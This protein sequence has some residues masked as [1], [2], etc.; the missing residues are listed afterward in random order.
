MNHEI[1]VILVALLILVIAVPS[2]LIGLSR[3]ET[4]IFSRSLYITD[5]VESDEGYVAYVQW[6]FRD[7]GNIYVRVEDPM[8]NSNCRPVVFSIWHV[9]DTELDSL[10]LRFATEPC[11]TSLFLKASSYEWPEM[12]LNQDGTGIL[13]S[14]RDLDWYGKGTIRLDFILDPD[15]HSSVLGLT[16]DFSM[17]YSGFIQLTKLEGHSFLDIQLGNPD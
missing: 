10:T 16:V 3:T 8:P 15:S 11:V 13:F 7:I 5:F 12:R 1:R 2:I 14:V 4:F 6:G 9:N 17:H